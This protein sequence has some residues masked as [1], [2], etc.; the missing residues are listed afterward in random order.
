MAEFDFALGACFCGNH[1][2]GRDVLFH[3]ARRT[4]C[5]VGGKGGEKNPE[6]FVWMVHSGGFYLVEKEKNPRLMSQTLHWFKWEAGITWITGFLLFGLMY[7]HGKLMVGFEDW[8]I[9]QGAAIAWSLGFIV[10]GWVAY[11]LLWRFVKNETVGVVISFAMIA[12]SAF[13][14][15]GGANID[16]F[17]WNLSLHPWHALFPNR[18]AFMLLGA[19]MGTIMGRTSGCGFCRRNAAWSRH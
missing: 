10:A 16:V 8:P 11:D 18:A 3:M 1:A 6:K 15:L 5:R 17:S 14:F 19:M 7:Y 4:F 13:I 12:I 2:G 9:S